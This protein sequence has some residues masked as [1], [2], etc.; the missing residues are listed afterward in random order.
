MRIAI[1]VDSSHKM[2][3]GHLARCQ[4]LA[5]ILKERGDEV[6]FLTRDFS[7]NKN[8]SSLSHADFEICPL[9]KSE[10]SDVA[11]SSE[12]LEWLAVSPEVDKEE[13]LKILEKVKPQW[14]IVD[15]YAL[16]FKWESPMRNVVK[17][18]MVIDDLA[19]RRHDADLLL[20][21]NFYINSKTRY[22][23]FISKACVKL[24]G[25]S[26][27]LLRKEF[28]LARKSSKVRDGNLKQILICFGGTDPSNE[29]FKVLQ[30]LKLLN[31][32]ELKVD[33]VVGSLHK[34][35]E[36]IKAICKSLPEVNFY[37]QINN[38]SELMIKADL[39]IGAGGGLTWE[40]SSLGLPAITTITAEN[41]R[42]QIDDL[43]AYGA[44]LRSGWFE[45]LTPKHYAELIKNIHR[46]KLISM[47]QKGYDLVDALGCTRAAE[48]LN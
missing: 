32:S 18:I 44:I 30:A 48:H 11:Y 13:T 15:H 40:R 23:G 42:Q 10:K 47:S 9:P 33:V 19:D 4:S 20:D 28:Q 16:D 37:C 35:R 22:D 25:P 5:R 41:Q 7:E 34:D 17:K 26:F 24:L 43:A 12:Y 31:I 1:R 6:F 27:A 2:G 8:A 38:I 3:T 46:E 36:E 39:S 21:Q 29:S 45:D 14:L